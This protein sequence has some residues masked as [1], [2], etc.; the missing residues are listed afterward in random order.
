MDFLAD[1][2]HTNLLNPDAMKLVDMVFFKFCII[3]PNAFDSMYADEQRLI[4]TKTLWAS[5]FTRMKILTPKQIK[6]AL[7]KCEL[8]PYPNPPQL[9]KFVEWCTPSAEEFGLLGKEQAYTRAYEFMRDGD[10]MGMSD[11][12]VTILIHAINQSDRHFLRNNSKSITEPV[13][14]RNYEIAIKQFIAGELKP[15]PKAIKG[16]AQDDDPWK[17]LKKYGGILPQYAHINSKEL[18]MPILHAKLPALA[19]L[20]NKRIKK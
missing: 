2:P 12:Q 16:P 19:T 3:Y 6:G 7:E 11:D 20:I 10:T 9:G 15:I 17:T 1:E 14:Y 4:A 5:T 18:A 13:F 8:S